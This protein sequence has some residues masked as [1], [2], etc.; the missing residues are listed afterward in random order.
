MYGVSE[1]KSH[2][3]RNHFAGNET[4]RLDGNHELREVVLTDDVLNALIHFIKGV[5]DNLF[6]ELAGFKVATGKQ[7]DEVCKLSSF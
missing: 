4:S 7:L 1:V 6:F 3:R 5:F 2:I